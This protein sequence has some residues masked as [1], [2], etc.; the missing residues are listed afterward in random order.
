MN[1]EGTIWESQLPCAHRHIGTPVW[2]EVKSGVQQGCPVLG[3]LFLLVIDWLMGRTDE[4]ENTGIRWT[5]TQKL[6]DIDFAD[7]LT[8]L[9]GTR[10]HIVRKLQQFDEI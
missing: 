10:T 4:G 3:Y 1:G 9:A 6:G 8:L 2:F 5:L 7:D